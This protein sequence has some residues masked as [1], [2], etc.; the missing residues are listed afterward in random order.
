MDRLSGIVPS[1]VIGI[2]SVTACIDLW[3]LNFLNLL[4][5]QSLLDLE[6]LSGSGRIGGVSSGTNS[7]I[8]CWFLGA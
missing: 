5:S 7:V 4:V 1:S 2:S 6:K 8:P 3:L